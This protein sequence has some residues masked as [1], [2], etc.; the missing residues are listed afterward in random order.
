MHLTSF[1]NNASARERR[2]RGGGGGGRERGEREREGREREREKR[3]G[4]R[5]REEGERG[6]REREERE[7]GE[8]ERERRGR[9]REKEGGRER[10]VKY[11]GQSHHSCKERKNKIRSPGEKNVSSLDYGG[12]EWQRFS[13]HIKPYVPVSLV[14]H[15]CIVHSSVNKPKQVM[16]PK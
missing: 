16:H 5:E 14:M 12:V 8:R 9:K 4:E 10:D 2:E 11:T 6:R 1:Y 13:C 7:A 15:T 3:E